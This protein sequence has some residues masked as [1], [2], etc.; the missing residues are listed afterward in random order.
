MGP[1]V[2]PPL[3]RVSVAGV[4]TSLPDVQIEISMIL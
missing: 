1:T 3:F 4:S 2:S